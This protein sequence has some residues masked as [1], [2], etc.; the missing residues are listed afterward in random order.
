MGSSS[1]IVLGLLLAGTVA[2]LCWVLI[3]VTSPTLTGLVL[4]GLGL[5]V[6]AARAYQVQPR[7]GLLWGMT[8]VL[9]KRPVS[10]AAAG[11]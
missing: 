7:N 9:G 11:P 4:L 10:T 5:I 2:W 6:L 1:K 3:G 8:A